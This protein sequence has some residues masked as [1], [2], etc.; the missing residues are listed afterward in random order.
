MPTI[1]SN[2]KNYWKPTLKPF[3][4][5]IAEACHVLSKWTNHYSSKYNNIKSESNEGIAFATVTEEKETKKSN[6]K[7]DITCFSCKKTG[8]CSN[9]CEE[10]LPKM[11][12]EKKGTSLFINKEDISDEELASD[13]QYESD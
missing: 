13:H 9:E 12:T 8:H 5:T 4:K 10:E 7:K 11:T 6:K 3:P 1:P 2:M